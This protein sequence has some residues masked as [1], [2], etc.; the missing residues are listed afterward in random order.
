MVAETN[1]HYYEPEYHGKVLALKEIAAI[2]AEKNL[3]GE[4]WETRMPSHFAHY[5]EAQVWNAETLEGYL[6]SAGSIHPGS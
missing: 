6:K 3:S 4:G 1:P 2:V 5:I